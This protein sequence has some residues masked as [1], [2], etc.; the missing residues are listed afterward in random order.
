MKRQ[1]YILRERSTE[2]SS[3]PRCRSCWSCSPNALGGTS[4]GSGDR[5]SLPYPQPNTFSGLTGQGFPRLSP[6]LPPGQHW[7]WAGRC[8]G[9][10]PTQPGAQ[11]ALCLVRCFAASLWTLDGFHT[12]A[13]SLLPWAP[14]CRRH[15]ALGKETLRGGSRF[16]CAS[17]G[18]PHAVPLPRLHGSVFP[19]MTADGRQSH[20]LVLNGDAAPLCRQDSPL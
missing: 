5:F 12:R 9:V 13:R 2:M 14:R 17:H 6:A 1:P 18:A 8:P 3:K 15:P 10:W 11:K 16:P 20:P 19:V 7:L 4:E